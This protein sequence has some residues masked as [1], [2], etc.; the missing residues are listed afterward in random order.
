MVLVEAS[1]P[2]IDAILACDIIGN[3]KISKAGEVGCV[4]GPRKRNIDWT[5]PEML[6]VSFLGTAR[7]P[8]RSRGGA[9]RSPLEKST[10]PFG[11]MK[12]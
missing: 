12:I 5:K 3:D 9:Y 10:T 1:S 6:L 8:D 2:K 11:Q 4:E 7:I